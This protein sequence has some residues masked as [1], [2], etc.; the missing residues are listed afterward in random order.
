M[1][2]ELE[3]SQKTQDLISK[4]YN[5]G[6]QAWD[7]GEVALSQVTRSRRIL[8]GGEVGNMNT[9]KTLLNTNDSVAWALLKGLDYLGKIEFS[10]NGGGW[11]Y[12]VINRELAR[13]L[14]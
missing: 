10:N 1:V 14:A 9:V 4:F 13:P 11:C 6:Q 2:T 3:L 7:A 12:R 8:T 5:K